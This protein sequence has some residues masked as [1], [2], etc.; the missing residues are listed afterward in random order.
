MSKPKRQGTAWETAIVKA[1][2]AYG[3]PARRLAEEGSNDPG[4]IQLGD[5][6]IL[7][8]R[9]RQN[10]NIHEALAKAK[11]KSPLPNTAV[12]WK[13]MKRKKPGQQRRRSAGPPI[14]AIDLPTF[15]QLISGKDD[16]V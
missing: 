3:I 11:R 4:D 12:V 10:M 13:R 9:H 8:A 1:A 7:E 14:V 6:W 16:T 2:H 15:L 5:T